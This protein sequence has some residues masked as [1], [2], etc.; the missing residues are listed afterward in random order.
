LFFAVREYASV[1]RILFL[2]F[3]DFREESILSQG[4]DIIFSLPGASGL[5]PGRG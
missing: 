5:Y 2:S 4:L 1:S 3:F